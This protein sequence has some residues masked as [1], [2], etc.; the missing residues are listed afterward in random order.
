MHSLVETNI[1]GR[2]SHYGKFFFFF[3]LQIV[4]I[5]TYWDS[6]KLF[7]SNSKAAE[8][9]FPFDLWSLL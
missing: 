2:P 4:L 6:D 1:R 5:S 9:A 7:Q 8:S 3:P